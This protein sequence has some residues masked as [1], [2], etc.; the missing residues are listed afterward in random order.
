M[1][2]DTPAEYESSAEQ[3]EQAPVHMTEEEEID[4]TRNYIPLLIVLIAVPFM[5][6]LFILIGYL[7]L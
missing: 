7:V 2:H 6:G 5:L 3:T 1:K 4:T